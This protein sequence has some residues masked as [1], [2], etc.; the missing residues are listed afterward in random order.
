M[1]LLRTLMIGVVAFTVNGGLRGQEKIDPETLVGLW[2]VTKGDPNIVN[3]GSTFQF[4]KDGGLVFVS[5]LKGKERK[6]DMTY[7]PQGR[8]GPAPNRHDQET[9]RQAAHLGRVEPQTD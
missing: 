1:N 9:Q 7:E 6:Y 3:N 2:E 4:A 8:E 5:K